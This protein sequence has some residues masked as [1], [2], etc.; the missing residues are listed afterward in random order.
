VQSNQI[1]LIPKQTLVQW[2]RAELHPRAVLG[3]RPSGRF[4]ANIGKAS[5]FFL[6]R[7]HRDGESRSDLQ[8]AIFDQTSVFSISAVWVR[9]RLTNVCSI[10]LKRRPRRRANFVLQFAKDGVRLSGD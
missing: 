3:S 6:N 8:S 5:D 7:N 10:K 9:H 2:G 4:T 1:K